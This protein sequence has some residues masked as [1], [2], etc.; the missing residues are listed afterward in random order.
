MRENLIQIKK[1]DMI[2]RNHQMGKVY[3][4]VNQVR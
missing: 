1:D 4:L 3:F 2:V